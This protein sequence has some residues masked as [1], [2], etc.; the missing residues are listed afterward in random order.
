MAV[1][2]LFGRLRDF[3]FPRSAADS[4]RENPVFKQAVANA[5]AIYGRIPLGQHIDAAAKDRLARRLYLELNEVCVAGNPKAVCREKLVQLMLEFAPLQV[6]MIPPPPSDDI[7]GLRAL[8]GIT[9]ELQ[10]RLGELRDGEIEW[11]LPGGRP[12]E[13]ETNGSGWENLRQSYWQTYWFLESFNALRVD[14]GDNVGTADWYKPFMHAVCVS[15][16]H[17]YRRELDLPPAFDEE[18]AQTVVTAFSIYTDVVVSGASDP[19]REWRDYCAGLGVPDFIRVDDAT[20][21]SS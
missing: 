3:F 18:I 4:A 10:S 16:E 12:R 15:Q 11:R 19:D 21:T 9:G 17:M 13:P 20:H 1:S 5:S 6:L 7:T 2:S 8:P 14:L